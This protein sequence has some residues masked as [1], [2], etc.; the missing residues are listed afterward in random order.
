MKV[1]VASSLHPTDDPRVFHKIAASLAKRHDVHLIAVGDDAEDRN[2]VSIHPFK[3]RGGKLLGT[4]CAWSAIMSQ[5]RAVR[6][7][8]FHFHDPDLV[9][10]G[11]LLSLFGKVKVVYDIHEDVSKTLLKKKWLPSALKRPLARLFDAFEKAAATRF[12]ALCIAEPYVKKRFPSS[13]AILVRNFPQ[14]VHDRPREPFSPD[15]PL[16]LI[17]AGSL[18]RIRGIQTII[19]ALEFIKTPV[20]LE[21]L[22]RFH[23]KQFEE[24]TL[25]RMQGKNASYLGCVPP[26]N[27][28]DYL[29]DADIGLCCLHPAP[30]HTESFATKLFEYMSARLPIIASDFPLWRQLVQDSGCGVCVDPENPEAIARAVDE[31]AGNPAQ[32][33]TMA[34]TGRALFESE[35]NWTREEESLLNM[36]DR[37]Q[38]GLEEQQPSADRTIP[39]PSAEEHNVPYEPDAYLNEDER[40]L[41]SIVIP[42]FNEARSIET[43]LRAL[44]ANDFLKEQFE[45]I[46][47]DGMSNDASRE[48]AESILEEMG[49]GQ[50]VSNPKRITPSALNIGAR[51]ARGDNI[52]ILGAHSAVAPDFLSENLEAL[53][54]NH[55]ADCVGGMLIPERS[56]SLFVNVINVAH[57]CPFGSGGAGFRYSSEPG[58]RN[59]VPFGAYR[60]DVF[61]K[62]GYFDEHLYKGQDA[63]FNFRMIDY[64]LKIFYSPEI[65]SQYFAR[66]SFRRLFRQFLD[67]GWSKVFIFHKHPLLLKSYYFAPLAF[68]LVTMGIA[69]RLPWASGYELLS[70]L[71][72]AACYILLSIYFGLSFA[73]RKGMILKSKIAAALIFPVAFFL[74][75]FSYGL[76]TLKGLLEL[77][78]SSLRTRRKKVEYRRML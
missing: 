56:E 17:Y 29:C 43:C 66:S 55:D 70:L 48:I 23:S 7:D 64:G 15:R 27:V 16:R 59:T 28:F 38:E 65:K 21:I 54:R 4:L 19:D 62:I 30:S 52:I 71:V 12:D 76:G 14:L 68:A 26:D 18:T 41:F 42:M 53:K 45:I 25:Q 60:R 49:N 47:V 63:E 2:G 74:M 10:L 22:G 6:P 36:Y 69:L 31:L 39:D 11:L 73:A 46:V 13:K 51:A 67:M 8:V 3:K 32:M 72:V 61:E 77:A 34:N 5:F 37:L 44:D 78:F 75:H 9:P 58:F 35:F 20:E 40:P 33:K 1:L 57:N 24:E 50:V